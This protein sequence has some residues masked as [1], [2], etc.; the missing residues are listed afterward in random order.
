MIAGRGGGGSWVNVMC[1][2]PSQYK[3]CVPK[4]WGPIPKLGFLVLLQEFQLTCCKA[5]SY[6]RC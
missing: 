1:K 5:M 4:H 6:L 3:D 2:R